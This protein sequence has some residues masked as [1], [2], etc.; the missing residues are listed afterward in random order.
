MTVCPLLWVLLHWSPTT[1]YC[2]LHKGSVYYDCRMNEAMRFCTVLL[3]PLSLHV[4]QLTGW[5][6][7]RLSSLL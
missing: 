6:D 4:W 2:T 1:L 7:H 5:C 3:G